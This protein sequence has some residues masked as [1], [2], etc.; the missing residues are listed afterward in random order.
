MIKPFPVM[1][2]KA[3]TK[4][5]RGKLG[6]PPNIMLKCFPNMLGKAPSKPVRAKLGHH[7]TK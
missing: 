7:L 5:V 4:P 6:H 1:L 3:P 2:G